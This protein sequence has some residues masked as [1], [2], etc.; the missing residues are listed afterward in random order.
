MKFVACQSYLYL[1]ALFIYVSQLRQMSTYKFYAYSGE[2][3]KILTGGLL[4]FGDESY[5]YI[6]KCFFQVYFLVLTYKL[7][8]TAL[9]EQ[10]RSMKKTL[11]RISKTVIYDVFGIL[12]II[13]RSE[14]NLLLELKE[15]KNC[16]KNFSIELKVALKTFTYRKTS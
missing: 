16:A 3:S 4:M 12:A 10:L 1:L 6:F 7:R 5:Q 9:I 13:L 2:R 11:G 8:V 14:E 15:S